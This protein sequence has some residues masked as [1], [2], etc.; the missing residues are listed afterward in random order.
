MLERGKHR[1]VHDMQKFLSQGGNL[2]HSSNTLTCK[3]TRELPI[4]LNGYKVSG[5]QDEE[6]LKI[7][8]WTIRLYLTFLN[9]TFMVKMV[10]FMLC[11]GF[12]NHN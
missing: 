9:C 3:A 7:C 4:E 10:K 1:V 2:C 12:F 11:G 5:L 6:I 8:Y